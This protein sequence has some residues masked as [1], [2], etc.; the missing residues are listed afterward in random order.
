MK[1]RIQALTC[2]QK[3]LLLGMLLMTL[4]F[5][6]LY[7]RTTSRVGFAYR[8]AILV[9]RQEDGATVYAGQIQGQ[10]AR[11]TVSSDRTVTFQFG[12]QTYG[13]YTITDAPA[14][15][16][17]DEEGADAMTGVEVRVGDK[18][19]FRGGVLKTLD[20]HRWLYSEDGAFDGGDVW[21]VSDGTVLDETGA[22]VDPAAPS[23][24]TLLELTD[25]PEL[26]HRGAWPM[27]FCAALVCA[28]NALFMLFAD[29]FFRWHL[30][31]R[32]RDAYDAEP[33]D[34]ELASRTI[35]WTFLAVMALVLFALG[36]L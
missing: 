23:V 14:A 31:F 35:S 3:I 28:V 2:Y 26:T 5:A 15:I 17:K 25:H 8:D 24:P 34:W 6:A 1:T 21:V 22:I 33:S 9:P 27:W 18:L 13:P 12:D 19:L 20:G 4:V 7:A 11:F 32:I 30:A 36:L 10:P 16:P 29:E